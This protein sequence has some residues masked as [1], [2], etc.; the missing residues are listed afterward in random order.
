MATV[1]TIK[2][3][4]LI[5]TIALAALPVHVTFRGSYRGSYPDRGS[6]P[7]ASSRLRLQETDARW[8]PVFTKTKKCHCL[9]CALP[10]AL[11][12]ALRWH[13][14][15]YLPY[16]FFLHLLMYGS[17]KHGGECLGRR[18]WNIY[19]A[20]T[21]CTCSTSKTVLINPD[22]T[23]CRMWCL[24]QAI[25]AQTQQQLQHSVIFQHRLP[26]HSPPC[27]PLPY[28]KRCKKKR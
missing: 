2:H 6:Y 16:I 20:H 19:T 21:S 28:I 5:A 24:E 23:S 13:L 17:G 3:R 4:C 9:S 27:L 12:D 18:C 15:V 1:A 22:I 11:K 7:A 26:R 14:F 10:L 25:Q 8:R